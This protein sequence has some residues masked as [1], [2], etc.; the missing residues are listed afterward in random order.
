[1]NLGRAMWCR[2]AILARLEAL[3]DPE[4][5]R[6]V[7]FRLCQETISNLRLAATLPGGG[8]PPSEINWRNH[9]KVGIE[10]P[11]EC[12]LQLPARYARYPSIHY[13]CMTRDAVAATDVC[14]RARAL[15]S[16]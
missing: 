14:V 4:P 9:F 8:S 11:T 12:T 6:H 16:I 10:P 15:P 7:L 1:M 3:Q 13:T 2:Q 5:N